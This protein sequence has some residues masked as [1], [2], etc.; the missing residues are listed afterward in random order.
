MGL[1]QVA[2]ARFR[3]GHGSIVPLK[4]PRRARGLA[5]ARIFAV[6]VNFASGEPIVGLCASGRPMRRHRPL[7]RASFACLLFVATGGC[8]L[9]KPA[10]GAI[11]GPAV[12]LGSTGSPFCGCDGR[13]VLAALAVTAA[14]G[15]A[16]G[17]VTG[18]ISDVQWLSGAAH[19]P[20]ANWNNP[21]KTNTSD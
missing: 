12:A 13:G 6:P 8:T 10:V 4:T 11:V 17:L 15:A 9:V 20:T 1:E 16:V 3:I 2:Q 21:F 14:A 19:D 18:V 5:A 7:V